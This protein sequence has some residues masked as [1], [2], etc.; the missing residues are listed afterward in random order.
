[1]SERIEGDAEHYVIGHNPHPMP[2]Q[3]GKNGNIHVDS[4]ANADDDDNAAPTTANTSHNA[5]H[6]NINGQAQAQ[7]SDEE[8][9]KDGDDKK[10]DVDMNPTVCA[11][12]EQRLQ[13]SIAILAQSAEDDMAQRP[14]DD[15][16][17]WNEHWND[18]VCLVEG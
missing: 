8:R 9:K 5:A 16:T 2:H 18:W 6:H 14:C 15:K 1:M 11:H 17:R 7:L 12:I 13:Q 10:K 3:L 4:N